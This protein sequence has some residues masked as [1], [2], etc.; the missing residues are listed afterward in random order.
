MA[1]RA[2]P[3]T[4]WSVGGNAAV[5]ANRFA[6]EGCDVL[7]GTKLTK[8][9][10]DRIHPLVTLAGNE[11][12]FTDKDDIHLCLEYKMAKSWGS[13]LASR[14]NRFIV[15]KDISNPYLT[16][17]ENFANDLVKFS[18][19][20]IVIGGLQMMDNF[21][22]KT[23]ERIALLKKLRDLLEQQ[24]MDVMIHFEMASF[25][26]KALL[27]ELTNYVLPY[28]DSIGM[29]EQELP[30]LKSILEHGT[31]TVV[32]DSVPRVA[33]TLDEMRGLYDILQTYQLPPEVH[34]GRRVSRLHVHTLAFQ[35][36]LT[37]QGSMWK[38]TPSAAAKASL[39]ANRHVCNSPRLVDLEKSR[40]ILDSSFSLSLKSGS[41][42]IFMENDNP[43]SCWMEDK[44]EFC[45]APGLVC[46]KV[47]KTAG[48]GDNISSA[49]LAIQV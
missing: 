20:L 17:L 46:T 24:P 39:T 45:I 5:M 42:R 44:K 10:A 14:A 16:S 13:Y 41:A 15:H 49:A 33:S 22:F 43:V 47:H 9:T 21:P 48:G 32:A 26:D 30:N 7:L 8:E 34:S 35:A 31:I 3:S 2:L 40:L 28:T 18:P 36:I 37:R 6:L 25:T 12:S 27:S 11:S 29:N 1:A 19:S 38:N 4:Q 23:G